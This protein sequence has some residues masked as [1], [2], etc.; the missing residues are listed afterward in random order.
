[1]RRR[2]TRAGRPRR[3]ALPRR[4]F[5]GC[6][7]TPAGHAAGPAGR[8]AGPA[9]GPPRRSRGVRLPHRARPPRS[10]PPRRP[11][12]WCRGARGRASAPSHARGR[13]PLRRRHRGRA[14]AQPSVRVRRP[15][16]RRVR[17]RRGRRA[18]R[19]DRGRCRGRWQRRARGGLRGGRS[20]S[21]SRTPS[22]GPG[23]AGTAPWCRSRSA[24]RSAAGRRGVQPDAEVLG[25]APAARRRHPSVRQPRPA[26]EVACP[27]GARAGA[28]GSSARSGWPAAGCRT[29]RT[30]PRG[31]L[32]SARGAARAVPAGCPASPPR[33]GLRCGR[34]GGRGSTDASNARASW[35]R[36]PATSSSS[37]PGQ[38]MVFTGL[39]DGEDHRDTLGQQSARNE[40]QR[41][42]RDPVQPLHV[43]DDADQGL[44]GGV[45]GQQAQPSQPDEELIRRRPGAEAER[46][47]QGVA[48][49]CGQVVQVT[50]QR[51]AQLV[52][53]R[54]G[55]L[56]P[57]FDAGG[58]RHLTSR[59]AAGQVVE[60]GGL[61][62]ARFAPQHQ[63][64]ALPGPDGA[65]EAVQRLAFGAPADQGW[66]RIAA[67]HGPPR[68]CL[69][70]VSTVSH[71]MGGARGHREGRPRPGRVRRAVRPARTCRNR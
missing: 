46:G 12:P 5:R 70:C 22:S 32:G 9:A 39:A 1:M 33:C 14:P 68:N 21:P 6:G 35:L 11:V 47:G 2:G 62:D 3:K 4:R 17:T 65:D 36:R 49:G 34:R 26:A 31:R 30:R 7:R 69:E 28:A 55:E 29:A 63:D 50:Q 19:G 67:G 13:T 57:G 59:R 24:A 40:R 66:R 53:T 60:Q 48:L 71:D 41:L 23:D 58:P 25:G 42:R 15:P 61:A 20:R 56:Q 8:A 27:S 44:V 18:R 37:R 38:Q 52:Q 51:G 43:V 64:P 16:P 45:R 10:W 54:V